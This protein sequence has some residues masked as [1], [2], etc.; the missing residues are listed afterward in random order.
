MSLMLRKACQEILDENGLGRFHARINDSTKCLTISTECGK[1]LVTL[2]GIQFNRVQPSA[3]EIEFA[4]ELL[5]SAIAKYRNQFTAYL[6]VWAELQAMPEP[7]HDNFTI[8]QVS[9]YRQPAYWKVEY[10]QKNGAS[11]QYTTKDDAIVFSSTQTVSN[12]SRIKTHA[13][14]EKEYQ[15]SL[16][17]LTEHKAY[18]KKQHEVN[19]LR[20]ELNKCDI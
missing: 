19:N 15:A 7:D 17:A 2:A 4:T 11:V 14:S 10:E 20:N 9:G 3:A 13:F 16:E 18:Q 8:Q 6:K 1:P 12:P 5:D